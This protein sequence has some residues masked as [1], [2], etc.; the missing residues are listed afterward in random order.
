MRFFYFVGIS[1]SVV[2][3]LNLI[4]VIVEMAMRDQ[5]YSCSS[6][7]KYD[8]VDVQNKCRKYK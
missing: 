4:P 2:A 5:V 8:P 6:I 3:I 7:G 1:L